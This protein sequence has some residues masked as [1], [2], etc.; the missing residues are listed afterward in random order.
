VNRLW[1]KLTL[2]F[3]AISLAAIGIVAVLS[4]R[5]TGQQFRQYVVASGMM[6][7]QPALTWSLTEY[8]ATSGSWDGVDELLAQLSPGG[9]GMGMGMGRGGT[10]AAGPNIAVVGADGRVVASRTGALVGEALPD[11]VLAQGVPLT[12]DGRLIG[13]VVSV[14][15]ADVVLDAQGEAFLRQ[16]RRSVAWAA[17]LAAI[18]SLALGVLVSRLLT[19]PLVQLTRAAQAVAA[20]DLSQRVPVQS[21]DEIG[22]LGDAFNEMTVSLAESETLRQ[23]LVADVS[24]ELRTPLTVMQGNLQAILEGV[25]P[26]E[27]GQMLSLYDE[28]RLLTRLVDDLHELTLADAG[29]LRLERLPL[30][31]S[32]LTRTAVNQ[33]GPVFEAASVTLELTMDENVPQVLG[34]ADRL[35]QVLRN[36]LGNALRHTP[37]GGRVAVR[38]ERSGEKAQ[39]RVSDTGAGIAPEDLP[40]VFDRFYRGDKS[41][42]RRGGGAGLG[43]A[44]ARQLVAAHGGQIEASSAIGN[45]TTFT[46][47]FPPAP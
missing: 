3:L 35:T 21:K 38:V 18:M 41:R 7:S 42:S 2:A 34:D 5:A 47:W 11:S 25:Y 23:N 9:M 24:H 39:I 30:N 12:L 31:L 20:G 29:Q 1:L 27:M 13:T 10:G 14:H 22:E 43:L 15:A 44:I 8:Y 46:I 26:L 19:A 45:G 16:V 36:L 37:A 40:H 6:G 17:L 33:F 4:A 32:D 28:T